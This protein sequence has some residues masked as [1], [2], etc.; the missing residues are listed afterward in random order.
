[1]QLPARRNQEEDQEMM[2][3]CIRPLENPAGN[4]EWVV[5][6]AESFVG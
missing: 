6:L 5:I 2:K 4:P 1:M 3:M